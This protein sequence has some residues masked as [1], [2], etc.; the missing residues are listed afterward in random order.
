MT[1]K[2]NK[3][4]YNNRIN[5]RRARSSP[6]IIYRDASVPYLSGTTIATIFVSLLSV[7]SVLLLKGRGK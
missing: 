1:M 4:M 6:I 5:R 3:I 2:I 7:L